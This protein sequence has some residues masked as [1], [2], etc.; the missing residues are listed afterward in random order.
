MTRAPPEPALQRGALATLAEQLAA[1][2]AGRIRAG[3]LAGGSRLPSVRDAAR[4][5]RL[6]PSTVVGL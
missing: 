4:R 6:A 3:A 2:Y 5:H 1:H